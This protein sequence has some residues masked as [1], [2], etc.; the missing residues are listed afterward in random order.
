LNLSELKFDPFKID[1][2]H[3]ADVEILAIAV[4]G[5]SEHGQEYGLTNEQIDVRA[6]ELG[7]I[8]VEPAG[9]E[10][11]VDIDQPLVPASFHTQYGIVSQFETLEG[12]KITK[13]RSG[14]KHIT[15]TFRRHLQPTEQVMYAALFGSDI[16]REALNLKNLRASKPRP[17]FFF[18]RN[19]NVT[20]QK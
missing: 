8:I 17:I 10:V 14:N 18:E 12:Y 11:Q 16:K 2:L 3:I 6:A 9:N 1:P 15:V 5:T 19:P 7:A 13:S 20:K 4:A